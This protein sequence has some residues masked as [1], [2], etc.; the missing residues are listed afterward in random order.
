[1][2]HIH[3][4]QINALAF[5]H[6][7]SLN[8]VF[9]HVLLEGYDGSG[10]RDYGDTTS[11]GD[12][13]WAAATGLGSSNFLFFEDS[14][15]NTASNDCQQGGSW[16]VRYNTFNNNGV[17]T[18]P[19]GGAGR[20]RGCRAW[21]IYGNQFVNPTTNNFNVFFMS[22]GTGVVWANRAPS[23]ISNFVTIHSMRRNNSTY[24]ESNSP[25]G[26][27]YCGSSFNGV[28]S[29]WDQNTNIVTGYPCIDQPGRGQG[30][31]LAG[32]FPNAV[33]TVMGSLSWPHQA[34]EPVYE[35]LNVWSGTGSFWANYSPDVLQANRDYYLY[36]PSFN[37][38]GGVGSGLLSARPST[39]TAGVAYW[40]TDQNT[41][42]KCSANAWT[43][44]YTPYSYP[45]PLAQ[46]STSNAG[47][48]AAPSNLT[49]NVQ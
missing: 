17:Q 19:T 15:F 43:V 24:S 34:L 9:D 12:G 3:F 4:K 18:H 5:I 48:V 13:N 49:A 38:T 33:N 44:L 27:G 16:V 10:W 41:L 30:D 35:W 7:G 36:T 2:D 37:G 32:D 28:A 39:C 26:W 42:Y 23:G 47:T 14:T 25:N 21:E 29:P 20:A 22:S 11:N 8:G 40:A 6:S 1:V 46:G 31:L 45:H